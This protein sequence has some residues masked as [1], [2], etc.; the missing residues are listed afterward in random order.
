MGDDDSTT[1]NDAIATG[2][3]GEEPA[4]TA[5]PGVRGRRPR[6][7][8]RLLSRRVHRYSFTG[9]SAALVML[10]LSVTPSLLPREP[11]FQGL[12]SAISAGTGYL[13]GTFASW[14]VRYLISRERPWPPP[15]RE[16]WFGLLVV[17]L[18]GTSIM[19]YWFARWQDEIRDLMGMPHMSW[20]AYPVIAV[21]A[22]VAFIVLIWLGWAWGDAVRFLAR[23]LDNYVPP[24]LAGVTS[25]LLVLVLTVLVLNGVVARYSMRAMN[26]SFASLND[27]TTAESE[28][29]TSPLRSGGPGSLV[30]WD[31]IGLQGR[32]FIGTG[33]TVAD[34]ERSNG[35]PAKEPV[36]S[37]VGLGED[38]DPRANARLAV[39]EMERSGAFDRKII[40][41]AGTTGTGWI[42][43]STVDSLEYMYNGDT[44]TVAIQYSYLPSWLS[45][46]VDNERSRR[47]GQA[48]FEAVSARIRT[49]PEAQR[50]KLVV[51]GE[52]LGTSGAEAP[53]STIPDIAART[54]GAFFTGPIVNNPLWK[55]TT[56]DRDKGSP[57]RLPVFENGD[58][59]RFVAGHDDIAEAEKRPWPT[60]SR[61]LFLQH[62]SDPVVWWDPGTILRKPD[63]LREK[64]GPDVH[65]DV[66]W[67]PLVTFLQI[68]ADMV[69]S[70]K[71]PDGHGHNYSTEIPYAWQ[72]ILRVPGWTD[73]KSAR[74]GPELA[75]Y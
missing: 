69:S 34:L 19:L 55:A 14:L 44:A 4:A 60:T 16:Y 48:L 46:L 63:W 70:D 40:A 18:I 65:P 1:S 59:V 37:Y 38:A 39:A 72:A 2:V 32:V 67:I 66:R 49:M 58:Q 53:F 74:L 73:D 41:V 61:I 20:H 45:F 27:E 47:S 42:N 36:R 29:T 35:T 28:P 71:V 23:R 33:P 26:S 68:S 56:R 11:V 17:A 24:R 12:I 62:A 52:S 51:F 75:R 9:L 25:V 21:I 5:E 10:W 15:R 6:R 64:R 8:R 57:E 7:A 22:H 31:S 30:T 13:L 54:D 50:P 3:I 43:R